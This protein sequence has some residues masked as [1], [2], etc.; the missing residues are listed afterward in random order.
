M[1]NGNDPIA[2]GNAI[3]TVADTIL[4]I[5]RSDPT[6]VGNWPSQI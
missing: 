6:F 2:P 5:S 4:T 3:E 1:E